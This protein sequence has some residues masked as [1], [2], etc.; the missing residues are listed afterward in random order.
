MNITPETRIADIASQNPST[1][2]V[3]QRFGIDF[4]CGG[5]RPVAEACS[6]K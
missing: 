6:E 5:K 1:I 2:R 4:C 3:F